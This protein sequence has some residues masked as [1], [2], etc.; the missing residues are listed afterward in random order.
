MGVVFHADA[1]PLTARAEYWQHILEDSFGPADL[2]VGGGLDA[3]DQLRIGDAGAVRVTELSISSRNEAERTR[4]HIRQLDREL[5]KVHVHTRG[6]GRVEQDGRQ[7]WLMPGDLTFADLTRPCRWAYSS[8]QFV[9]VAFPRALLPVSAEELRQLN[10]VRI[11]GARGLSALLATLARQLPGHLDDC[12]PTERARLGTAVLDLVTAAVA[13]RLDHTRDV[14][15][16]SRQRALVMRVLAFID[17][18]LGDPGLSPAAIA[19]AHH[20][21]VSYLYKLFETQPAPVAEWIRQR[22]LQRCRRDLLDPALR[23]TPVSTIAARW[24]FPSA[25]HFSRLF[26][27]IHGLPPGEYRALLTASQPERQP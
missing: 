23:H 6:R 26:R 21:S 14:P 3:R 24:G 11:P 8:A 17:E 25:A 16:E 18:R 15:P 22:R 27:A 13:A 5:Y 9:S 19:S 20:I 10:G 7:T 2:R 1:E 4:T 12:G